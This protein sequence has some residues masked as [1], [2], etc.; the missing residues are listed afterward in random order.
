M[1]LTREVKQTDPPRLLHDM[2]DKIYNSQLRI[3]KISCCGR[4]K[5]V[6]E[7]WLYIR[8]KA[9]DEEEAGKGG[10]VM[11]KLDKLGKNKK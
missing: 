4:T 7:G 11:E 9:R 6:H 5:M 3:D 2:K 10:K 8:V 1:R